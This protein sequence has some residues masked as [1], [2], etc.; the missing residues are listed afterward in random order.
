MV[1][2]DEVGGGGGGRRDKVGRGVLKPT[3]AV[4]PILNIFSPIITTQVNSSSTSVWDAGVTREDGGEGGCRGPVRP[5][6]G[7]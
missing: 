7:S 3:S 6:T 5:A 1:E 4:P 2:G